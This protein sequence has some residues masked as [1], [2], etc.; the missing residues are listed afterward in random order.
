MAVSNNIIAILN[1]LALLYSIPIIGAGI[2]LASKS[3][4]E[5]I[6]YFRWLVILIGILILLVSLVGFIFCIAILIMLLLTLLVLTFVV[7]RLD[8][9]YVV[10]DRGYKEYRLKGFSSWLCNH[11]THSTNWGKIR[12]CL[13]NSNVCSKLSQDYITM[14]QFF[15]AHISPFLV[16]LGDSM[17][18]GCVYILNLQSAICYQRS[19]TSSGDLLPVV[20]NLQFIYI[21]MRFLHEILCRFN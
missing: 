17:F 11:V 9:S 1:F 3:D 4:N 19:L 14:D 21:F 16:N 7:T 18:D 20:M 10:P 2:W 15:I 6:H 8:R 13:T 12:T 5:C